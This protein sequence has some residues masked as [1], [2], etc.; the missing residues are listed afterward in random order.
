MP[1]FFYSY[2]KKKSVKFFLCLYYWLLWEDYYSE[3]TNRRAI[4]L[5]LKKHTVT[6]DGSKSATAD[7]WPC[8][9]SRT[10]WEPA[11]YS[12]WFPHWK[13]PWSGFRSGFW[14]R[15]TSLKWSLR[16]GQSD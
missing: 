12:P 8:L 9:Y 10:Y 15:L 5:R 16:P 7:I 2:W 3:L 6:R 14:G 1:T 13:R 4:P 11:S